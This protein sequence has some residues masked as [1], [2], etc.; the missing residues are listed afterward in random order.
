MGICHSFR[1]WPG[2]TRTPAPRDDTPW[3]GTADN[4]WDAG[5]LFAHLGVLY[6][7][8]IRSGETERHGRGVNVARRAVIVIIVFHRRRRCVLMLC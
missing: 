4:T 7:T 8:P 1:Q 6:G 5:R 2:S 3:N